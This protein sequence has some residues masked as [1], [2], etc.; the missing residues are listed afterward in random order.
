MEEL[1]EIVVFR[2]F[3]NAIA[4]NIAKTKLDAY[5][6]PVDIN[7]GDCGLKQLGHQLLGKPNGFIFQTNL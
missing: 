2:S 3:E 4:A 7:I 5:G 6:V 1:D